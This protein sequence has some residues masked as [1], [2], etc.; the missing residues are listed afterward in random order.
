M[1]SGP[2]PDTTAHHAKD[3]TF[4]FDGP[5]GTFDRASLQRGFQV[6][7]EV[8]SVCHSLKLVSFHTLHDAGG[9]EFSEAQMKAIAAGFQVPADPDEQGRTYDDSGQR[10]KRA[11]IPA[12]YFPSPYENEKAGR[13]ANNGS[14]PP[15]LSVMAKAREGGPR[16]IYSLLTG[17]GERPP[18]NLP[19]TEN[20]H[21]NPYFPGHQIAMIPP[22][23]QGVV[24]YSDGTQATVDQMARD[25]TTFL[26]WTAE[27]KME[28]RKRMG[29]GVIAF[30]LAL[31]TLL[32]LTYRKVWHGKHDVD[33]T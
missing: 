11:G 3:V 15:D 9:P 30:L 10:M 8:C 20:M 24:T 27:P 31:S 19:M 17:Y 22:L 29:F 5:F 6:Y 2:P 13:A 33:V 23:T 16:Y 18:A 4:S 14:L 25:V 12:D 26:M 1:P 21:Y 7:K 32:Y 28:E